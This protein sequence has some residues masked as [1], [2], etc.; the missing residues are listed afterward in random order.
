MSRPILTLLSATLLTAGL[1]SLYAFSILLEPLQ[2]QLQADRADVSAVFSL[3]AAA[4]TV[5]MCLTPLVYRRVRPAALAGGACLLA[6]AGLLV[7]SEV[8]TLPAVWVGFGILFGLANGVGYSVGIQAVNVAWTDHRG[9]ATGLVVAMYAGG[10]IAA[11]PLLRLGVAHLGVLGTLRAMAAFFVVASVVSSLLMALSNVSIGPAAVAGADPAMETRR[12]VFWLLWLVLA[13]GAAAGLMVIGHAAGVVARVGGTSMLAMLGTA[14]VATGN[15]T[16][17]VCA[18]WLTDRVAVRWILLSILMPAALGLFLL[19]AVPEPAVAVFSLT[20]MGLAYGAT[21]GT[22]PAAVGLYYGAGRIGAQ[23]GKVFTAWGLA[24]L[25]AP[26]FAGM[27]FDV[28]GN[29]GMA[30]L[31]AAICTALAALAGAALPAP[32]KQAG[33]TIRSA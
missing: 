10:A 14:S 33:E 15:M 17:R 13:F 8:G 6:T 1:G 31:A 12:R 21:A 7:A 28:T 5:S 24:G 26:Y 3:A 22:V 11:A 2:R 16:G 25:T 19:A 18:G 4:F 9:L 30:I 32:R 29:Y 20:L 23:F 27:L